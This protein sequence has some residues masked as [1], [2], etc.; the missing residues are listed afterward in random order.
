MDNSLLIKNVLLDGE[1]KTLLCRD[2][3]FVSLD[4]APGAEAARVIDAEGLA[5]LPAFY[6]THTH[7]AMTLMR[8]YGDDR[9]LHE[10]LEQWVWPYEDSLGAKDI[11]RGSEIAIREMISTGTVF[12]NDMYFFIDETIDL[13]KASGMRAAIGV[14]LMDNHPKALRDEKSALVR[15]WKDSERLLLTVAP[16]SVYTASKDTLQEAAKL[17]RENGRKIHIHISETAKEVKEC[18]AKT[19]MTP[20]RY[21]DSLGL[22][23]PDV[24]AAH[25]VHV[26]KEEWDILAERGVTVSHCPCSNMKLGS[27]RFPYELAIASGARITLGTDGCSSNNNLDMREEMKTAALLAKVTGDAALLSASQVLKWATRNGAE[28]FGYD[29]GEIARGRLADAILVD[30]GNPKMNPC[31]N[32]ISNW[33][34][35]ADSSCIKYVICNGKVL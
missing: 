28:A 30:L 5:I 18:L 1:K 23:G 11:R 25:C 34:Y 14:T 8:G 13:V 33:V 22:L 32:L 24:I 35:A 7:A 4:A 31:H 3:R 20:V 2:G 6:N 26:D 27:G 17:A 9:P 29:A 16:H 12:F 21:L 15:A 19:G 10:W